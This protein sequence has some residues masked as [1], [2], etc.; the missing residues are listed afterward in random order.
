M[1][2]QLAHDWETDGDCPIC[3]GPA[4]LWSLE[5]RIAK[6]VK[7]DRCG[8]FTLEDM[9]GFSVTSGQLSVEN[10]IF[11]SVC[12]ILTERGSS[13]DF[14]T[15]EDIQSAI[16]AVHPPR[17][18]NEKLDMTLSAISNRQNRVDR[19]AQILSDWDYPLAFCHDPEEFDELVEMLR[20]QGLIQTE[21]AMGDGGLRL[22]AEG[23][24]R[25]S[26]LEDV[27]TDSDQAFVA[28][29]FC[30]E[31][32]SAYDDGFFI[33]LKATGWRPV[34]ADRVEHAG[35]INDFIAS[36]IRE[37]GLVV[38]DFTFGNRGAYFEAG[39]AFGLPKQVIW[40][41]RSDQLDDLHFDI[42][43]YSNILWDDPNDLAVK[44]ERRIR[45]MGLAR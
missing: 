5:Q 16:S 18:V 17:N 8:L 41:C 32:T 44:L 42:R 3:K 10:H 9:V 23:W 29:D 21:E 27:T 25:S 39:L 14:H 24:Q 26:L 38:A 6:R 31:L 19:D 35:S 28:M 22:T 15:E 33:G 45:G 37:S 30:D 40:T 12:R 11:S 34:R 2:P 36:Q 43:Q 20:S 4:N 7:C 13:P 1:S